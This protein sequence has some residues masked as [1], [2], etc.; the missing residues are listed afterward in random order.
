MALFEYQAKDSA[1]RQVSGTL[2]AGDRRS[3]L[4]QAREQ[5]LWI[6][7][8]REVQPKAIPQ[9]A[10]FSGAS[11]KEM[12]VCFRQ[13]ATMLNAGLSLLQCLRT[14]VAQTSNRRL[15]EALGSMAEEVQTGRSLSSAMSHHPSLFSPLQIR[16]VEAGE[17]GGMLDRMLNRIAEYLEHEYEIRLLLNK[18]TA[19][20]KILAVL[21]LLIANVP[22]LVLQG[23]LPFLSSI[24]SIALIVLIPL[25]LIWLFLRLGHLSVQ[26]RLWLDRVKLALP[27]W[28]KVTRQLAIAKFARALAALYGAGV[29]LPRAAQLSAEACGNAVISGNLMPAIPMLERGQGMT[30]SFRQTRV[31]P[32]MVLGMLSTG[33]QTGSMDEMMD[34]VADYYEAEAEVAI[35][36]MASA[37]GPLLYLAIA[38]PIVLTVLNFWTKYYGGVFQELGNWQ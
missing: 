33:E 35:R 22:T 31:F 4:N 34:K 16:L 8:L 10:I 2:E 38:I 37:S 3:A 18:A 25:G 11:L 15:R 13:F 12:M 26:G 9:S 24:A 29:H 20:P 19:Y 14:L 32:E 36:Q 17:T 21:A 30:E 1:G 5:G 6:T 28:G 23:P 27:I 7:D